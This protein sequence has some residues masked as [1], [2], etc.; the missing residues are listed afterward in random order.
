SWSENRASRSSE[1]P[2][3]EIASA[4]RARQKTHS[5]LIDQN[6]LGKR[7]SLH[8][9]SEVQPPLRSSSLGSCAFSRFGACELLVT[10]LLESDRELFS[11]RANDSSCGEHMHLVRND[12]IQQSLV[13][14]DDDCR[15]IR[16]PKFVDALCDDAQCIDVE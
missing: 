3:R 10:F 2:Q 11:T 7:E 1:F 14:R 9:A 16:S 5:L 6:L 8:R 4:T 15:I 13:M 12:V